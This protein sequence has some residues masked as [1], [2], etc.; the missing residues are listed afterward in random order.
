MVEMAKKA[1][2][3]GST[4]ELEDAI[5]NKDTIRIPE[6]MRIPQGTTRDL[7]SITRPKNHK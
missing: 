3:T 1:M 6:G 7:L 5:R 2:L 4:K